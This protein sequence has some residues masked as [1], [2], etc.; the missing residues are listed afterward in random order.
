MDDI[1]LATVT[2]PL[3]QP[4]GLIVPVDSPLELLLARLEMRRNLIHFCSPFPVHPRVCGEYAERG[5][6]VAFGEGSPPRMRGILS[7]VRE[8]RVAV[9]GSPPRMRGIRR[10]GY[11]LVARMGFTPA[12]AGNIVFCPEFAPSTRGSPPRM[13]GICNGMD[14]ELPQRRFT[15]AYAGNILDNQQVYQR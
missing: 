8:S 11:D 6:L 13:R 14:S 10:R 5:I 4:C 15:P 12:Y 3:G 2:E 1:A 7:G 9:R